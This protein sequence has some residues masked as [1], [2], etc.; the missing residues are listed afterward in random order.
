MLALTERSVSVRSVGVS[1]PVTDEQ[2]ADEA[3]VAAYRSGGHDGVVAFGGGEVDQAARDE[4]RAD[5][6]WSAITERDR[7]FLDADQT[8]ELIARES[9]QFIRTASGVFRFGYRLRG[10]Q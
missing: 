4:E 8:T 10:G 9:S 7:R 1:L 5:A 3:G 6:A 2:L